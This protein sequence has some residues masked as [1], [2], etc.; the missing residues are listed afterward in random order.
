[1]TEI[2]HV[3]GNKL[4][5]LR[6]SAGLSLEACSERAEMSVTFLGEIERGRKEPSLRTLMK[7]SRAMGIPLQSMIAGLDSEE[8][9]VVSKGQLLERLGAILAEHYSE[10]EAR[11]ICCFIT[12]LR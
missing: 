9:D 10:P 6:Q 5:Q 4:R 3:V 2:A 11:A 7:L 8:P 1:M 12:A